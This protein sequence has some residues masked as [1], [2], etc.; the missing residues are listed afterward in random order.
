MLSALAYTEFFGDGARLADLQAKL[1]EANIA[2]KAAQKA[3]IQSARGVSGSSDTVEQLEAAN[4]DLKKQ[5]DD[6]KSISTGTAGAPVSPAILAET[7]RSIMRSAG[8][9]G[10]SQQR[11]FLLKTRL[12]LTDGQEAK[13]KAA[14]DADNSAR[15]DLM[16]QWFQNGKIDPA[17]AAKANTLDGVIKSELG[18]DQQAQYKAVQTEEKTARADTM[19]TVQVNSVAPLL[20]LSDTQRDAVFNALYQAQSSAPDPMSMV[21]DPNALGTL[22]AQAAATQTALAKVLTPD[23]MTLY[24]QQVQNGGFGGPGMGGFG[25]RRGGGGNN[26]GNGGGNR[27]PQPQ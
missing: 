24:Q 3:H 4:A 10:M 22:S 8:P 7:L 12:K 16:R 15:R 27:P 2:L 19:A 6:L 25:G 21:S 11:M 17:A 26:G 13:I 14:M 1:D 5:V 23:Q 9:G 18:A 20:Q